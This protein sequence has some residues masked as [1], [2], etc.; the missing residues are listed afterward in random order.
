[1]EQLLEQ[2]T[3][4]R[5]VHARG[6]LLKRAQGPQRMGT[7]TRY[8][9]DQGPNSFLD[10]VPQLLP[11]SLGATPL[12]RASYADHHHPQREL[13]S[14]DTAPYPQ[15]RWGHHCPTPS[16]N[17]GKKDECRFCIHQGPANPEARMT[18]PSPTRRMV[19]TFDQPQN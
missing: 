6:Y 19:P 14:Q 1:M 15:L 5:C 4:I 9:M 11:H 8:R 13:L 7:A 17:A 3:R 16:V 2:V 12:F 10:H 18:T